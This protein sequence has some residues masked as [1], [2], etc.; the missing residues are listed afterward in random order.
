MVLS[1][2]IVQRKIQSALERCSLNLHRTHTRSGFAEMTDV[3]LRVGAAA[4]AGG[5]G[6]GWL[7]VPDLY[8][9]HS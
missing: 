2:K 8:S 1:N 3:G 4:A 9:G 5:S 7:E 6:I